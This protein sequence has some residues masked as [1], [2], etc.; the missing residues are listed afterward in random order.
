MWFRS[1]DGNHVVLIDV[2]GGKE[3]TVTDKVRKLQKT[4]LAMQAD[5][6]LRK[7]QGMSAVTV[8]GVIL[9]PACKTP[10]THR[11]AGTSSTITTVR[12]RKAR[13]LLGGLDQLFRYMTPA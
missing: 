2:T 9:A 10:S 4:I 12:G 3:I 8:H 7:E 13:N 5:Q 6:A 11:T 1:T